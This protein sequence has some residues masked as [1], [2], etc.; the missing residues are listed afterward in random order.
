[1]QCT[2]CSATGKHLTRL[3]HGWKRSHDNEPV[4]A[5]CWGERYTLRA[6]TIPVVGPVDGTWKELRD[7]LRDAWADATALSNWLMTEYY[8]RDARRNGQ[9]KLP[10]QP[11]TYLYPEATMRFPSIPSKAVAAIDHSISG[12]YRAARYKLIWTGGVSLPTYRFPAP[13]VIPSQAWRADYGKDGVPLVHVTLRR[14]TR[15][16]TLRLRGGR[17]YR[18]QLVAFAQMVAGVAVVGEMALSRQRASAA[19]HRNG[20]ADRDSG[21]QQARYR[22]MCKMVAWLPREPARK[23]GGVLF[24][25][26]DKDSLLIVLNAKEEKLWVL[27]SDHV[28]RWEAEY[29][30]KLNR[31]SNDQKAENRPPKFQSR[32]EADSTKYRRRIDSACHEAAAQLVNYAARRRFGVIR[33]NDA[34]RDFVGQFPW[35]RLRR[36]I[37]EKADAKGIIFELVDASGSVVK[38]TPA[39]LAA[40]HDKV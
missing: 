32:R 3:P 16:W 14:S 13:V 8:V 24:A 36:L 21:G 17:E 23:G 19:D 1:M 29:R 11:Q 4:C 15:R 27:N 34:I 28:R 6:V 39:P 7:D 20:V 30:R 26:T 35:D 12:K 38:D 37:R 2:Y 31:W 5:K 25:R 33:Y 40:G 22:V 10:P 9:V 18:R